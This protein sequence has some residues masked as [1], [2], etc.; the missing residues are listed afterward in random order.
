MLWRHAIMGLMA[1]VAFPA[2]ADQSRITILFHVRP[3]YALQESG[4]HV[5][6]ILVD[7]VAAA[8]AKAGIGADWSEMPP[9]RQTEEIKRAKEPVCGLG[10]F[11]RPERESF[12]L[13]SEPI[14]Q[15]QPTIIV[16]RRN[17][18][19]FS[20]GMS[21]QDNFRDAARMLIVKTGYSYG[22]AIDGWIKALQPRAETSSGSNELLLGMV[23]QAR[24][25]Y[26]IMAP[27]EAQ[28]LLGTKPALG[29]S[30][31]TV[32]L[33]DAPDGELR[34]LMCSRA[35]PLELIARINDALAQSGSVIPKAP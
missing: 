19:R 33:S 23:A 17:D 9:A 34:H 14:Y 21:L 2:A 22:A 35:T 1:L 13:F 3:P 30:L 25:D 15:D 16:A 10:W 12:A 32:R 18:V 26:A 8:L 28:D 6:G 20:D 4:D 27:E 11:K 31:R 7:P 5:T 29:A 24:V